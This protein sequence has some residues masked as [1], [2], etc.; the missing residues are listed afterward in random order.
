MPLTHKALEDG[1][2]LGL[3]YINE[4]FGGENH[5][6][7]LDTNHSSDLFYVTFD[8]NLQDFDVKN[9]NQRYYDANN[10]MECIHT[11]QRLISLLKTNGWFG[12]FDHPAPEIAGEKLSPE[13]IQNVPP[14]YRAFK[15]MNPQLKGNILTAKIQS[16]QGEIGEG[17]GKEVLAG[18]IPQFS[19]RAIANMISK[20]GKPYVNVRKL[21]TYDAPWFPSH[22]VAHATSAPSVTHKS[23]TESVK[24][25]LDGIKESVKKE[26]FDVLIPLKEILEEVGRKDVNAQVIMEAF[27]LGIED[28]VG[29]TGDHSKVI[30]YNNGDKIFANV[31]PNTVKMVDDYYQS[32]DL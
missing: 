7:N 21:I 22:A 15:I 23:F 4:S 11:D 30:L 2:D 27:D 19:C 12:E 3:L 13:R 10:I 9:R 16:A 6:S 26:T 25:K 32:F 1:S 24:E 17:F 28:M 20:N 5:V 31:N 18:W 29:F 14:K 8:T